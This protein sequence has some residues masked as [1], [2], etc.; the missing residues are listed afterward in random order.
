MLFYKISSKKNFQ[1]TC[2]K[3]KNTIAQLNIIHRDK[4]SKGKT[5]IERIDNPAVRQ[6]S[7]ATI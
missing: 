2:N 5:V 1:E 7:N 4:S 6:L 3:G